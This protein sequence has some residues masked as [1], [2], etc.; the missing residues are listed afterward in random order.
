MPAE[1]LD[2]NVDDL[3][4]RLF[5]RDT[6]FPTKKETIRSFDCV[7]DPHDV[8]EAVIPILRALIPQHV[9]IYE[10]LPVKIRAGRRWPA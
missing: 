6:G 10:I 4:S 7:V 9:A 3:L 8:S 1:V 2:N 5:A